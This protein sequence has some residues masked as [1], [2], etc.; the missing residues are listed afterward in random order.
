MY[1]VAPFL[2]DVVGVLLMPRFVGVVPSIVFVGPCAVVVVPI[3]PSIVG[4]VVDVVVVM[5]LVW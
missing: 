2:G 1:R 5:S 3:G 4:M